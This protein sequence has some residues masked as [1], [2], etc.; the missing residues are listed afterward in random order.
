MSTARGMT[1]NAFMAGFVFTGTVYDV[2]SANRLE[3]S[4]SGTPIV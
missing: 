2:T 3:I 1:T 4:D